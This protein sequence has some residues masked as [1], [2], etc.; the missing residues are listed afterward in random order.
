MYILYHS[1]PIVKLKEKFMEIRI[2]ESPLALGQSAARQAAA[3]LRGAIRENGRAR[4]VL[5]TGASQFETIAALAAEDVDWSKVEMF[6]LDE[7]VGL[8]DTHPASFRKYLR[9]RFLAN[10]KIGAYHLVDGDPACIPALSAELRSAPIDLGLIGIGQNGHIAFNDPPADFASE[11]AY[12]VVDLDEACKAQQVSEGWFAT[13]AD[14]PKQAIT[15]TVRQI[16]KCRRI[17][18]CVPHDVKAQAVRDTV[19]G[20]KSPK[21]PATALKSHADWTLCLD[22][23]SAALILR[24][25]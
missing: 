1:A 18:S 17:I 13:N 5:S 10:I 25:A 21:V 24:D 12:I 7:Y 4:L 2:C 9:E 8:P 3:I 23:A 11:E 16:L 22:R 14:V 6:H 15:M 19:F 20:E